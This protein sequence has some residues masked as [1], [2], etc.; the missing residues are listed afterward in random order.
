[1]PLFSLLCKHYPYSENIHR[2]G[3][4]CRR[5]LMHSVANDLINLNR[6]DRAILYTLKTQVY[7]CIFSLVKINTDT[8]YVE[9][10]QKRLKKMKKKKKERT[11]ILIHNK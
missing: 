1:M 5:Q 4:I 10:K 3:S 8:K 9:I 11:H 7:V 2:R 6:L